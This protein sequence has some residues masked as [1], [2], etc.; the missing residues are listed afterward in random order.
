MLA[1]TGVGVGQG[2]FG[3]PNNNSIMAAAPAQFTGEAGGLM[4]VVR[5]CGMSIGVAAASTLLSWRI[6]VLT[7][8][9]GNTIGIPDAL[10]S[11]SRDVVLLVAGFAGAAAAISF[12][13]THP[14][15]RPNAS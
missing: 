3:A 15:A 6:E 14:R 10:A 2:L 7:G 11:A 5:C 4:N 1:L 13:P 9:I 8:Q 12:A